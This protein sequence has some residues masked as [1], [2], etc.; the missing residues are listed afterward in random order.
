MRR[1]EGETALSGIPD[2]STP[3]TETLEFQD[4]RS[5]SAIESAQ[6]EIFREE[7]EFVPTS[8]SVG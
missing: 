3:K 1:R 5:L 4:S 7:A 6:P 2:A 8:G